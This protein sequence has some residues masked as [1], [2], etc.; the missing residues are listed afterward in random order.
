MSLFLAL[1]DL[2]LRKKLDLRFVIAHF[3]HRLRGRESDADEQF[4]KD[5]A[6]ERQ[7]ELAIGHG[8]IGQEGNMEQN[9]RLARYA[10]LTTTA[11]NLRARYVLTAHTMNDQAETFLLNLIRGSGFDGLGAMRTVRELENKAE[12]DP[13]NEDGG[14]PMLPFSSM[15]STPLLFRP[16]IRWAQ[17][18]DT[19]NFCREQGVEFRYDTMNEDMSFKRV[20]VRKM[21][22]PMLKEFNPN[23]IGTLCNTADLMQANA[24]PAGIGVRDPVPDQLSV[25][26]LKL[27]E[28]GALHRLLRNWLKVRRG[29][30]R[31]LSRKHIDAI[32]VLALSEKS[33][34]TVELPGFGVV[35]KQN[36][37]LVFENLKV[38]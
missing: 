16:L 29:S 27:I 7:F 34:K 10:F 18:E 2:Q 23:I 22:L 4:V 9:A 13:G 31:T 11:G 3:N 12:P 38:D 15:N 35:R 32:G 30:T 8:P 19:E 1:S 5:F 17:R 26:E 20:R 25:G 36:G 28:H 21:L 24:N 14:S 6:A 37:R 33:G